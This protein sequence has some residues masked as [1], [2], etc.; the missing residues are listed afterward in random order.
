MAA[1]QP[2]NA[3]KITSSG[4]WLSSGK[5]ARP[6]DA[7][8]CEMKAMGWCKVK[9]ASHYELRTYAKQCERVP[10]AA[11]GFE[12]TPRLPRRGF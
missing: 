1:E 3:P 9:S 12:P 5:S 2:D 6:R 10:L 4:R 7:R 8:L 11:V